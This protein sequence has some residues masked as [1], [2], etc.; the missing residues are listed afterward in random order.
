MFANQN[1]WWVVTWLILTRTTFLPFRSARSP[2]TV[3]M[4]SFVASQ[5]GGLAVNVPGSMPG[6][7]SE[8]VE[9]VSISARHGAPSNTQSTY[10]PLV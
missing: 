2:V 4:R 8:M 3:V 5:P 1:W 7:T 9:P 10:S 6:R